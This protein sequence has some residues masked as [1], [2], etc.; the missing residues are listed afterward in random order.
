MSYI[1]L[2]PQV[3]HQTLSLQRMAITFFVTFQHSTYQLIDIKSNS[4]HSNLQFTPIFISP[5]MQ[6]QTCR[7]VGW[8]A[9]G[10]RG[11]NQNYPRL[12]LIHLKLKSRQKKV[13]VLLFSFTMFKS[14]GP[15][16]HSQNVMT[17]YVVLELDPRGRTK[18]FSY[19]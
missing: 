11:C 16:R 10:V 12:P 17:N 8:P 2:A 9:G 5:S 3:Y 13:H 4:C 1:T 7:V 6:K 18:V 14:P 19:S 15:D